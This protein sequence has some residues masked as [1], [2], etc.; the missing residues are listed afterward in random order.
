MTNQKSTVNIHA[1]I[2]R[3]LNMSYNVIFYDHND[4]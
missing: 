1:N 4:Q 2:Q 3:T